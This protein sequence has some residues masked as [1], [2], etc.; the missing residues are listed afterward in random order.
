MQ[1]IV[2]NSDAEG[3]LKMTDMDTQKTEQFSSMSE[4]EARYRELSERLNSL[5]SEK[6][7]DETRREERN[8][9]IGSAFYTK[10][11]P[12]F[13]KR[14]L[15]MATIL[16]LT[17]TVMLG[18][19]TYAWFILSSAPEVS[20]LSAMVGANGSLEVALVN[21]ETGA[22][23][24]KI[25]AKRGDTMQET[26]KVASNVTWGN[27]VDLG[28]DSYGLGKIYLSPATLNTEVSDNGTPLAIA[29]NGTDGRILSTMTP[30]KYYSYSGSEFSAGSHYGVR[31]IGSKAMAE[32]LTGVTSFYG[33]AV[34]LAFR[35]TENT[36]LQLQTEGVNRVTDGAGTMGAGST[37]KLVPKKG[38]TA[39]LEGVKEL[40]KV[41]RVI[42][43]DPE[44]NEIYA[45]AKPDL[46]D[47]LKDDGDDYV[48][49]LKCIDDSGKFSS[50]SKITELKATVPK[51][52]CAAFYLE[53]EELDVMT[54]RNNT[55]TVKMNLQFSSSTELRTMSETMEG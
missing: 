55:G 19:S 16:L 9:D 10:W 8:R 43:F 1:M 52:V 15:F 13:L 31:M 5:E 29:A 2:I 41:V 32:T 42:F 27:L 49:D 18:M 23:L 54:L 34:D 51:I 33:Y 44:T 38:T 40:F 3:E 39:T 50:S 14:K 12:R 20:G 25:T 24:T 47:G 37:V 53:G 36:D 22:D 4:L 30:T 7:E 45:T 48:A 35:C 46:Q 6:R 21:D 11:D 17:S 28:D 26:S